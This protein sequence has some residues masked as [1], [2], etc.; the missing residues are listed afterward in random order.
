MSI[1][2]GVFM[3]VIAAAVGL[4]VKTHRGGAASATSIMQAAE[5]PAKDVRR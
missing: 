1:Q 4:F 5:A 3:L 2:L